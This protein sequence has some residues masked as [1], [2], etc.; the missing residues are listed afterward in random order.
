MAKGKQQKIKDK[1]STLVQYISQ[2]GYKTAITLDN[3]IELTINVYGTFGKLLVR[4]HLFQPLD[5]ESEYNYRRLRISW[6]IPPNECL[7]HNRWYLETT[8]QDVIFNTLLFDFIN[9][10]LDNINTS[11]VDSSN[12]L[13]YTILKDWLK[14]KESSF[15]I[16]PQTPKLSI[17]DK[18]LK[19]LKIPLF[20]KK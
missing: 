3:Q 6:A 13:V 1:Y 17:R 12:L 18:L 9:Y 4:I 8:S 7:G 14:D 19:V 20:K 11:S 16:K 15:D 5:S 2:L 10:K